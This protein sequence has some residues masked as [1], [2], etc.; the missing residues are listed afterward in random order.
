MQQSCP[1]QNSFCSE[2]IFFFRPML[3][4]EIKLCERERERET[5]LAKLKRVSQIF[6]KDSHICSSL[7][8]WT[9]DVVLVA[10]NCANQNAQSFYVDPWTPTRTC[11]KTVEGGVKT[12]AA[13]ECNER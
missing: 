6:K 8:R 11:V 4:F 7:A 12:F 1:L 13:L 2:E 3:L 5:F 10:A 9:F